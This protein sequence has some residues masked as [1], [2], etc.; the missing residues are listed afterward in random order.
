MNLALRN[1]IEQAKIAT[2]ILHRQVRQAAF[3]DEGFDISSL[4]IQ[5]GKEKAYPDPRDMSRLDLIVVHIT[6]V[7]G[8]FGVSPKA[9]TRWQKRIACGDIPAELRRQI[10]DA[11]QTNIQAMARR[12]ALW[13]RYRACP[14]QRIAAANGDVIR[15]HP[16]E[17]R[18]WHA[19]GANTGVGW[20]LDIGPKD[21][22]EP[23]HIETGRA[24]LDGL[25]SDVLCQSSHAWEH[26]VRIVPHRASSR[27][28]R[29][30]TGANV[31]REIVLP[32]VRHWA[33]HARVD[34][35]FRIGSGLPVPITW[36]PDARYDAKGRPL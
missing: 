27:D 31:W 29:A 13:E 32:M 34:Y 20:A 16:L 18:S 10:A 25:I 2:G 11:G 3:R 12:L 21:R 4:P 15:N 24:A 23:W 33:T 17:R 8:G 7:N 28:R 6:G 30:D 36:D 9:V 35:D 26:G 1:A 22:L 19:N 5:K 14:Y